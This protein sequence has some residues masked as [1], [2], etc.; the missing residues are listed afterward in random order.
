MH[1]NEQ[2]EHERRA[3]RK[4]KRVRRLGADA[5]CGVCGTGDTT[6]LQRD[7]DGALCYECAAAR[8]NK[9][10]VE[11]DHIIGRGHASDTVLTPGNIH[12]FKSDRQQD[13]PEEVQKNPRRDPLV[14]AAAILR[15][16]RDTGE[17]LSQ[18]AGALSDWLLEL[19]ERLR[20][21][22]GEYWWQSMGLSNPMGAQDE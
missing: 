19:S 14:W 2:R 5:R 16:L 1:E 20:R 17:W 22:Y 11:A 7:G 12:R 21:D 6:T 13:W 8:T 18:R 15:W 9:A 4:A 3:Q 10:T